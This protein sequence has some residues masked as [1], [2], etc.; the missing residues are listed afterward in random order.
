MRAP[1]TPLE[2]FHAAGHGLPLWV[3]FQCVAVLLAFGWFVQMSRGHNARLRPCLALAFGGAV[4]GA[5]LLEA[6]FRL[7]AWWGTG[8]PLSALLGGVTAYGALLGLSSSF[9]ALARLRGARAAEAL[10]LLAPC[11]GALVLFGRLGCFFAGC[12]FGAVSGVPWAVRFPAGS[13]AFAD[14]VGRGLIL[15]ADHRSLPVHPTQLYEALLGALVALVALAA[16]RRRLRPG[17]AFCSAAATYAAGRLI[18]DALRG[19]LDA[20]RWGRWAPSQWVSAAILAIIL[21]FLLR[22]R[23]NRAISSSGRARASER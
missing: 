21:A 11:M 5:T 8:K 13:P 17:A 3:I 7:P 1:G 20:P 12:D 19:D 15:A 18:I 23:M 4:A 16:Q 10:D 2:T 22:G 6:L 9:A 14:H